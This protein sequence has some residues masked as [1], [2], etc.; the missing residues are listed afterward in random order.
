[1]RP[2]HHVPGFHM[3]QLRTGYGQGCHGATQIDFETY[4]CIPLLQTTSVLSIL[5]PCGQDVTIAAHTNRR[6]CRKVVELAA[7]RSRLRFE[8][9]W[10]LLAITAS[11]AKAR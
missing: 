10:R 2:A 11:K 6:P 7:H 1:M 4:V 3:R 5:A 9:A 8:R